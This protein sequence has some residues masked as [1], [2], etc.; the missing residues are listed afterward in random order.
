MTDALRGR[1]RVDA[2]PKGRVAGFAYDRTFLGA[3][4]A[5][6]GNGVRRGASWDGDNGQ[7][8]DAFVLEETSGTVRL[9]W[10]KPSVRRGQPWYLAGIGDGDDLRLE[11]FDDWSPVVRTGEWFDLDQRRLL[12]GV[13]AVSLILDPAAGSVSLPSAPRD[14]RP[15]SM[16]VVHVGPDGRARDLARFEPVLAVPSG[17]PGPWFLPSGTTLLYGGFGL[18]SVHAEVAAVPGSNSV[19]LPVAPV[20]ALSGSPSVAVLGERVVP[21]SGTARLLLSGTSLVPLRAA[22]DWFSATTAPISGAVLRVVDASAFPAS[23]LLLVDDGPRRRGV[24]AYASRTATAFSGLSGDLAPYNAGAAVRSILNVSIPA[25]RG[26][27]LSGIPL[28]DPFLLDYAASGVACSLDRESGTCTVS[29]L[30]GPHAA[31]VAVDYA[32][33][34]ALAYD[35]AGSTELRSVGLSLNPLLRGTSC[36][37]LWVSSDPVV[38]KEIRLR[39]ID[40]PFDGTSVVGPVGAG[41]DSVAFEAMLLGNG[42]VPAAG[43]VAAVVDGRPGAGRIDGV[44]VSAGPAFKTADAAG[45][46][47]FVYTPPDSVGE[48]GYFVPAG[49]LVAGSGLLLTTPVDAVEFEG[50]TLYVVRSDDD[51]IPFSEQSVLADRVADGTFEIAAARTTATDGSTAFS[52]VV[53]ATLLDGSG[54]PVSSGLVSTVVF[55]AGSV[56]AGSG[57]GAYFVSAQ[58]RVRIGAVSDWGTVASASCEVAV[59]VPPFLR[60]EFLWGDPASSSTSSI[61]SLAYLTLNPRAAAALADDRTDPLSVGNVF[62][63]VRPEAATLLRN[64]F[65]AGLDFDA[66]AADGNVDG[67]QRLRAGFAFRNRFIVEAD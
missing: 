15:L 53:P 18:R 48:L 19:R 32:P 7:A 33:G 66:L 9:P 55:P 2:A 41:V 50:A 8:F 47:R 36:G 12:L 22:S 3:D 1:F 38:P 59:T 39:P 43:R 28:A 64:V 6:G 25:G 46:V 42:G 56:P 24:V 54:L 4:P 45:T 60:G 21:V 52:P 13:G 40:V 58:R 20:L 17:A 30:E 44:P 51:A 62:G 10:N 67:R 61:D 35:P 29:G 31:V 65:Y 63:V 16:A 49:N 14:F 23:G 27:T 57:V 37:V 5:P 26:T 11:T 34:I